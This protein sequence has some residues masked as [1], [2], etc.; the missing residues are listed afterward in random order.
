MTWPLETMRA[1]VRE[2]CEEHAGD[3][4]LSVAVERQ[5]ERMY[6]LAEPFGLPAPNVEWDECGVAFSWLSQRHNGSVSLAVDTDS[7]DDVWLMRLSHNTADETH[8]PSDEE[9]VSALV[10]VRS[11]LD[12]S[13]ARCHM[14]A[15]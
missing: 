14:G 4:M 7:S 5:L 6:A 10:L 1:K 12:E 8:E 11:W 15:S 3:A 9:I 2:L 13:L